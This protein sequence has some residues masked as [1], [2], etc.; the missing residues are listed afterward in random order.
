MK[1]IGFSKVLLF[2]SFWCVLGS[3]NHDR[4]VSLSC[5]KLHIFWFCVEF[6]HLQ[7]HFLFSFVTEN[8]N[9]K[10]FLIAFIPY[11]FQRV[12][13]CVQV[14]KR[15]NMFVEFLKRRI[16]FLWQKEGTE[17]DRLCE[18]CL[19]VADIGSLRTLIIM[20]LFLC[21]GRTVNFEFKQKA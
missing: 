11:K 2:D 9:T 13:F 15:T 3:E 5:M 7:K 8:W 18:N 16:T 17:L 10:H 12:S 4:I 21:A 6:W 20:S 14:S 19:V 1:S